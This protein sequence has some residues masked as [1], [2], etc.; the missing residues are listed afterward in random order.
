MG[1][2]RFDTEV[3]RVLRE[4]P[5]MHCGEKLGKDPHIAYRWERF[6]VKCFQELFPKKFVK[7]AKAF[8]DD[9]GS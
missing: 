6:H 4:R 7:F 8:S 9:T 2:P 5:C 3:G 1:L